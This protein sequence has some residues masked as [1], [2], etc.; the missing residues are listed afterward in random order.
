[1]GRLNGALTLSGVAIAVST[2]VWMHRAMG[3]DLRLFV[4]PEALAVVIGGTIAALLVSYPAHVRSGALASVF[5]MSRRRAA[6]IET[7]IPIFIGLAYTARRQGWSAVEGEI[8]RQAHPFLARAVGLSSSGLPPHV[9]RDTMEA[10]AR[11]AAE[12]EEEYAQLFAAAARYAP[13]LGV[14]G[15]LLGL[16]RAVEQATPAGVTSGL[17]SALVATVYGVALSIL[18]FQPLAT[19]LRAW[20]RVN[21]RCRELTIHG[22]MAIREGAAPSIVQERLAGYLHRART[23]LAD[24]A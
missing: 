13:A 8:E 23:P 22:V 6:P 11:I 16:M 3:G 14:L 1:M 2:I 5:E 10:E 7:L 18:L 4:Q 15:G 21:A 12:R 20:A 19:R 17:A 9:V 24:A